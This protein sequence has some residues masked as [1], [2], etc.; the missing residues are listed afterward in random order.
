MMVV[1]DVEEIFVP[2][3]E[4]LFVDPQESRSQICLRGTD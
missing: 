3:Q 4:E 1:A 2:M